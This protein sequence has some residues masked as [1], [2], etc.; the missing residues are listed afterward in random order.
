MVGVE[1][2]NSRGRSIDRSREPGLKKPRLAEEAAPPEIRDRGGSNGVLGRAPFP[3]RSVKFR[4]ER[5]GE[6]GYNPEPPQQHQQQQ[7]QHQELVSRYKTALAELTFNSKPIITNLTIIA[8]ENL[9]AAKWI[10]GTVCANILEVPSDQKL[11]SLYL[12]DSIV[13]NIGRDYIK[14]FAA[15]LPEVFSKA[16]RQV[17]PSIHPGMRHL[18][19]T[20]KGVFPVSCLQ[21]IEKELGFSSATNGSSSGVATSKAD[22]QS[23]RPPHSI[24]VNP[25]YLEA[26]QRLQQSSK[27]F[28]L[29]QREVSREL[30][31]EKINS[32]ELED[33]E[34][35]SE[36]SRHSDSG[37]TRADERVTDQE[38]IDKPWYGTGRSV[39]EASASQRVAFEG[40]RD[41]SKYRAS[42]S[43]QPAVKLQ[44]A[45]LMTNSVNRSS[46]TVNRNWK[47]SEEEEYMWDDMNSRLTDNGRREIS[48]KDSWMTDDTEKLEV[49]DQFVQPRGEHDT[50]SRTSRES[51]VDSYSMT[52]RG[53][54]AFGH[55]TS[56]FPLREPH[57]EDGLVHM[58]I[59]SRISGQSEGH[60]SSLGRSASIG[61]SVARTEHQ[62]NM[63]L[64]VNDIPNVGSFVN[65]G[66]SER[67]LGQQRHQNSHSA[68][69][70]RQL[71][72][73]P[74][75]HSPSSLAARQGP[76]K[77]SELD[78]LQDSSISQAGSKASTFAGQLN[79]VSPVQIDS[80]PF[81]LLSKSHKPFSMQNLQSTH[82]Q[83]PRH[84]QNSSVPFTQQRSH[85]S[86]SQ[87]PPSDP[88]QSQPLGQI[89]KQQPHA[90]FGAPVIG[91]PASDHSSNLATDVP[92]QSSPGSLLAAIMRSGLLSNNSVSSGSS[93]VNLH[94]SGTVPSHL[95]VQPPLPSGPPP[96]QLVKPSSMITPVSLPPSHASSTTTS[97]QRVPVLPP[98]PPGPPPSF[99]VIGTSTQS[100]GSTSES[101]PLSSLLS[102]LVAKGLISKP[103]KES[104]AVATPQIPS[105]PQNQ[106]SSATT[107][108]SMPVS[109]SPAPPTAVAKSSGK[110][111]LVR[112][113]AAK[114]INAG[115]QATASEKEA[116][117]GIAFKPD[118][119]REFHPVV[120]SGLFDDLPFQCNI[121]GLRLKLQEQLDQHFEWH[122]LKNQE[123]S[124]LN[125]MSRR[126][127]PSLDFWITGSAGCTSAAVS[128]NEEASEPMVP[129]DETQ[130]VCILCGELFEDFYSHEKDEWMFIGAMYLSIPVDEAG[131]MDGGARQ[132]PIVHAKC[133]TPSSAID[134]G[135]AKKTEQVM[136][137]D[138]T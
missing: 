73:A 25:K 10:A 5:D 134:L 29:P 52:L 46:S 121:C 125:A 133:V 69:P 45:V 33:Y 87:Q 74:N 136:E 116:L 90:T 42:K 26:R 85:S 123:P 53:Q 43:A 39:T 21:T 22:P 132:G 108:G 101:N 49:E 104:P 95:N 31:H 23:Q 91:Q 17:D 2:E 114:G 86:F 19:G 59:S 70:S 129:A 130:S 92:G 7:Q 16:Y 100:G 78:V 112:E 107:S 109:S 113:S 88:R 44:P 80:D 67:I 32:A 34:C 51:S 64:Q 98:L 57:A 68:S 12:L 8:G 76:H 62:T 4:A 103:K 77:F 127:Y 72:V 20:W 24:H 61:S 82:T 15:K 105:L 81:S 48:R 28:K 54:G 131:S 122:T 55:R 30:V 96:V 126:W 27:D 83:L 137:R 50:G 128:A 40:K 3:S 13:K 118:V 18:F 79:R 71:P 75:P 38:G 6:V 60:L 47:N 9:H 37:F 99:S 11:P 94:E 117:V 97:S 124:S 56:M 65:S 35:S 58:G 115:S 66:S 63:R 1:M 111:P 135:L 120:I 102:S 110:E 41:F 119:I 84:I 14:Y 106:I 138:D 36:F 93:N 89:Q